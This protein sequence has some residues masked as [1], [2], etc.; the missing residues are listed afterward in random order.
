MVDTRGG[1]SVEE[2]GRTLGISVA[3]VRRDLARIEARGLVERTRGGA[4][5]S[6]NV[7]LGPTIAESRRVNPAEKEAIGREAARLVNDGD[8]LMLDGGFTTFQVARHIASKNVSVVTKSFDVVQALL[9]KDDVSVVMV[10]GE[11]DRVSGTAVGSMTN[12]S[13][14]G[15]SVAKAILGAD[16]VSVEAGL[17]SPT[18]LTADT[19]KSM[20]DCA[21]QLIVV[22]DHSKLGK[23]ALYQVAALGAIDTLV[24]DDKADVGL[25][26]AFREAGVEVIVAS[27]IVET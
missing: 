20:N 14:A 1:A 19:K 16:A 2:I 13:L 10:G 5:P 4:T 23:F 22:A 15:F 18:P 3:T 8:T 7:A 24:T 25:L 26:E 9:S 11:F 12:K 21:H 27:D 6:Q 17:C